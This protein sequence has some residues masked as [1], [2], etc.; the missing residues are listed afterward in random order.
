MSTSLDRNLEILDRILEKYPLENKG[1]QEK[2]SME[3]KIEEFAQ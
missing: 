3:E 2:R 1:D